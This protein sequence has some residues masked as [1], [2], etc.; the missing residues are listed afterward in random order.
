MYSVIIP[1]RNESANIA[2]CIRSVV[3]S[4]GDH[5]ELE[6]LVVDNGSI[7]NTRE[8]AE[9]EGAEVIVDTT[10][11][12]S[13]LR[14]IG[15]R[16]SAHE[17]VAFI[18]ADCEACPGWLEN[19]ERILQD[20]SVGIVGDYYRLPPSPGWIE[21][22]LFS[23]IPRYRREVSYLSGGNM[24]MRRE[25]FLQVNGF[26]ESTITGEDYVLCL[27]M[28]NAGYRI[29]ADPD[30]SVIHHGNARTLSGYFKREVWC[31]LGML[32]LVRYDK[33]TLPFIW[34]IL[35]S[36]LLIFILFNLTIG[37]LHQALPFILV[38]ALL[39]GGAVVLK[40]MKS[41][42]FDNLFR[43]YVVYS[44]YG[45]ARTFSLFKRLKLEMKNLLLLDP[46]YPHS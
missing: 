30:V 38:L 12:I 14:N 37:A 26:D 40:S 39:P 6:I 21:T 35:N 5:H 9:Q 29:M 17:I 36:L 31:G 46:H 8:I 10:A 44:V 27:R 19:A 41:G 18:D 15:V 25:T 13:G 33:I 32:D 3:D 34:S 43:S 24:V 28:K 23:N 11:N 1:A 7:D 20:N 16:R 2:R 45:F 42:A 4:A 22:V